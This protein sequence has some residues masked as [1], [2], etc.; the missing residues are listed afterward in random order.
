MLDFL[1][2]LVFTII[3]TDAFF[4]FSAHAFITRANLGHKLHPTYCQRTW[5]TQVT[6]IQK[7]FPG[8]A[9]AWCINACSSSCFIF[10]AIVKVIELISHISRYETHKYYHNL[11]CQLH[12]TNYLIL[13]RLMP[14]SHFL[15]NLYVRILKPC[16][17]SGYQLQS[18]RMTTD[19]SNLPCMTQYQVKFYSWPC[20]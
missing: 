5:N 19:L 12:T 18:S 11:D 2:R 6:I 1:Y 20:I 7:H 3:F 15:P 10:I 4:T 16:P 17:L 8:L 13:Y 9:C 14:F